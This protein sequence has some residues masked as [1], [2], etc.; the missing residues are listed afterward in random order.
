MKLQAL[1]ERFIAFRRALGE[2]C[3]TAASRLRAFSCAV[4]AGARVGDVRP[5]QVLAFLNGDGTVT[6]TWHS[7][8]YAL[9][10]F[11]RYALSRGF[12]AADP[13]PAVIPRQPPAFVPYIYSREELRRLF[14][15]AGEKAFPLRLVE[16][17]TLRTILFLLYG[18]G[19]RVG[20]ALGLDCGDVDL[21]SATLTVRDTKFFKSRLVPFGAALGQALSAYAAWREASHP[22]P[23]SHAPFFVGR[24]GACPK[25]VGLR[26]AFRRVCD[27]VGVRRAGG[28][29]CQPRL[30]DLRHTFA[31]HRLTA[32]YHQGADVQRLLP[33]LSVYLGHA[34]LA[35]TQTYLSMTPELLR[36]AGARF[37]H[38]AAPE[39]C[40][41]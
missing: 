35:S 24:T 14:A 20:E 9:R 3:E 16:P 19:L 7:R 31:V 6:R 10:A 12:V 11:Y 37:E 23:G 38:Y 30:H 5:A 27:R 2:R 40:H 28:T 25:P 33:Q 21:A 26:V 17:L 41:D 1:I 32:W 8:Y 29:G 18:A 36:Q 39:G 34:H 22:P 4:G 15:A 13:L